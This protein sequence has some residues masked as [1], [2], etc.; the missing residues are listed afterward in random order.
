MI[1]RGGV[2]AAVAVIAVGCV[3]AG[4]SAAA[5]AETTADATIKATSASTWDPAT[6]SVST[7]DTVTWDTSGSTNVHNVQPKSGGDVDPNWAKFYGDYSNTEKYSFTFTQPGT[8]TFVC[9]AHQPGMSGSVTVTGAPA[10]PTATPSATATTSATA[11]PS[12]T[13]SP[14][15][16][17]SAT[18]TATP[19]STTPAPTRSALLDKTAPTLSKLK[20]K[21][22]SGGAKVAFTLSESAAVTIRAKRGTST[23]RTVRLSA[24]AGTRSITVRGSKLVRGTYTFE[25]EAR[26]AR[27]NKAPVQRKNVK[28]TR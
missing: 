12:A 23:L 19:G 15:A 6:V 5:A 22:V 24:R 28:V 13:A 9:E 18:P 21:A 1:R 20:L 16:T 11:T 26:D 14:R 27:G 2:R 17:V 7:G 8:Y 4:V 3:I 25:I 10:T